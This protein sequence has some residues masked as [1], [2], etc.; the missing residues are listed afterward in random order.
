MEILDK[1]GS[2]MKRKSELT[3]AIAMAALAV[4]VATSVHAQDKYSLKSPRGIAFSDFRGTRTWQWFL[5]P[6][7]TKCL[8]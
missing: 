8:R 5:P 6:G 4:L 7:P 1:K 2:A 3:I